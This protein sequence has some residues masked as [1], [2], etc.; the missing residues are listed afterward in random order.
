MMA[1][2]TDTHLES[3]RCQRCGRPLKDP[4]SRARGIGPV[5]LRRMRPEPRDPQ[6]LGVQVAVTVNGRPL[7]HVVRHSPTGFEWGYDGSGPADLALSILTDYLSRAGRD[8][9]VKDMP[10]AVVGRKGRELLAER[11]HQG[12][13]RDVVAC[14]PREGWRLTGEEVAAWLVR[15]GVAVPSM[16]VVYEG[17]RLA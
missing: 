9:R 2:V 10:E 3:S 13:K 8:V 17:R 14:L 12:F 1:L 15:H 11:L 7:G 6:G 16:P 5:C 4:T